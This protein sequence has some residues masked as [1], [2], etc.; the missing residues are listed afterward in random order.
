MNGIKEANVL[1]NVSF[2]KAELNRAVKK[3][4]MSSPGKIR[5]VTLR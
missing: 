5:R 2:T 1:I 3:A 4:K